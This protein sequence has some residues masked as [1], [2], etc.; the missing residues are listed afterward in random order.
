MADV[1]EEQEEAPGEAQDV[2]MAGTETETAAR[3]ATDTETEIGTGVLA[4]DD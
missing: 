3:P 2:M 4:T 1:D